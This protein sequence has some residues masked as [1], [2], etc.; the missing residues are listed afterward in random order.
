MFAVPVRS[1]IAVGDKTTVVTLNG[2]VRTLTE[3]VSELLLPKS[4]V[5]ATA[6]L[7]PLPIPVA[8]D[9][10]PQTVP[11]HLFDDADAW[12][13]DAYLD[14]RQPHLGDADPSMHG[15]AAKRPLAQHHLHYPTPQTSSA[16]K[17]N[18]IRTLNHDQ[19]HQGDRIASCEG[20]SVDA[21]DSD[22]EGRRHIENHRRESACTC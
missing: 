13:V 16:P 19:I 12:N 22:L 20:V 9:V 2:S 5:A 1:T 10:E 6:A 14:A 21:A 8:V 7:S 3:P 15:A 11:P 17:S 4:T 18:V